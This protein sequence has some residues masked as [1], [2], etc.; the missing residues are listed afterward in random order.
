MLKT[1]KYEIKDIND[2]VLDLAEE[3]KNGWKLY[4]FGWPN[5]ALSCRCNPDITVEVTL[6]KEF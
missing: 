3:I 5:V 6:S 2:V 4:S 1:I